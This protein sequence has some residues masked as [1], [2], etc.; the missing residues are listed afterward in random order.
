MQFDTVT[1][2][3]VMASPREQLTDLLKQARI[4]AG[5]KSHGAFAKKLAV[6]RS[7][8]SKAESATQPIPTNETLEAWADATGADAA[9]FR[10]LAEDA[11]NGSPEWFMPFRDA[12]ASASIVHYWS[13]MHVPGPFQTE[14]YAREVFSLG[15]HTPEKLAELVEGR[16]ERKDVFGR[17]RVTAVIDQNVLQR[18]IGSASVMAEQCAYL[19]KL[20]EMPGVALHV[21]PEPANGG[22]GG[23]MSLATSAKDNATTLCLT[24]TLEDVTTTAAHQVANAMQVFVRLLGA[25]MPCAESLEFIKTMEEQWRARM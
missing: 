2:G 9:E 3:S 25:A 23:A 20:A 7:L 11:R 6:S 5:Y 21:M 8:I 10:K 12:E 18:F 16:L 22:L 4:A 15:D 14:P 19:V 17:A 24:T 13:P 1:K